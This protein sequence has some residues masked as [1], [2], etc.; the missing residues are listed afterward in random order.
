MDKISQ[1]K[2]EIDRPDLIRYEDDYDIIEVRP[3][4]WEMIIT[5][6]ET[7]EEYDGGEFDNREEA[8]EA[9]KEEIYNLENDRDQ[10]EDELENDDDEE[11]DFEE[12]DIE[13][14][15]DED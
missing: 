6:K 13:H 4:S 5:D 8:Y 3:T 1:S 11:D 10:A 9:F 7:G 14:E 15:E 12:I 2:K